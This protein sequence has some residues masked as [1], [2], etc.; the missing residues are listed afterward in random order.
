MHIVLTHPKIPQNTGNIVRT[1]SVTGTSLTLIKPLGFDISDKMVKR[2]G[3]DYW[4]EVDIT[5]EKDLDAFLESAYAPFY[6]FTTKTDRPYTDVPYTKDSILV[7][8]AETTGIPKPI[9][10]KYHDRCVTLPMVAE[11]RC[12]N[13]S[14]AVSIALYEAWRQNNFAFSEAQLL[15]HE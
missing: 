7:F 4:D 2:A 10:E 15:S 14:N 13:L 12:L 1:C 6:L 5:V 3:L 8:G 11:K 9:L